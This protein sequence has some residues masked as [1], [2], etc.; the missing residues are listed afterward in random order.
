MAHELG[1]VNARHSA[2]RIS[3]QQAALRGSIQRRIDDMVAF[4]LDHDD[5]HNA[6]IVEKQRLRLRQTRDFEVTYAGAEASV[7]SSVQ[8]FGGNAR[9]VT[10]LPKNVL[11]DATVDSVRAL[12]V[13]F[14]TAMTRA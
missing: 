14:S 7:A 12:G 4:Y 8:Y 2:E 1:H 3:A 5:D 11:G 13:D 10:A 9:F 6:V